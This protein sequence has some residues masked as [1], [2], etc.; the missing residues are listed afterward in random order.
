MAWMTLEIDLLR[1]RKAPLELKVEQIRRRLEEAKE[2]EVA[3][4]LYYARDQRSTGQ[5]VEDGE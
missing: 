2:A 5:K 1:T 3:A 4:S